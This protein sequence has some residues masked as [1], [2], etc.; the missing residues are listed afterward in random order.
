MTEIKECKNALKGKRL[1]VIF[2]GLFVFVQNMRRGRRA[3]ITALLPNVG[4]YHGYL[5]GNWLSEL[6]LAPGDYALTGVETGDGEFNR[7]DHFLFRNCRTRPSVSRFELYAQLSLPQPEF[8]WSLR[9][10]DM[11]ARTRRGELVTVRA[12]HT[13]VFVYRVSEKGELFDIRLGEHPWAPDADYVS[14]FANL[15]VFNSPETRPRVAHHLDEF[16]TA[17]SLLNNIE[18]RLDDTPPLLPGIPG[19]NSFPAAVQ[20]VARAELEDLSSRNIR[21]GEMGRLIRKIMLRA[22]KGYS[23]NKWLDL[24]SVWEVIDELSEPLS[25]TTPGG[26]GGG[27]DGGGG[28]GGD[29]GGEG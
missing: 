12:A 6:S 22:D 13:H 18:L 28:T 21:L 24:G 27:E 10:V 5:A 25:C 7:R 19:R 4:P 17:T 26:Q 23:P 15:H 1:N 11:P 20:G 3:G 16:Q 9:S 2:H 29:E 8:I 14:D